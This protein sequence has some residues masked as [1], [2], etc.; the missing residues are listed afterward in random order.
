MDGR[1]PN[2]KLEYPCD[3]PTQARWFVMYVA[4]IGKSRG[5]VITHIDI[6]E[7]KRAE[8]EIQRLA[9]YDPLTNLANRRLLE[10]RLHHAVTSA[11]R[12]GAHGALFFID[13]DYFKALNDT[14]GHDVGDMLLVEVARRLCEVVREND[15]VAR[16]GGDE[17]VVLMEDLGMTADEAA[18][19]AAHLG[20]KLR[21]ALDVPFDLKGYE[22]YCKTSIGVG[23]F[24]GHNTVDELLKHADLAL[25]EA[26]NAGRGRLQFFDPAMQHALTRRSALESALRK[27]IALEQ[28]RLYYQPQIDEK[29]GVIGVEALLRWQH[30]QCGLVMPDHFISLAED[31]GL[32]LPVGH[33][34]LETACAQLKTW[35]SDRRN[36]QL[37]IAVNV[38]ARQFQQPDFVMQIQR[39]LVASGINPAR[40]K[41]ELT[42]SMLLED[43]NDAVAKMLEIKKLGVGLSM[44]DFGT[45]YSSLSHLAQLPLNQIKIDRSFVSNIQ[46]TRKDETIVQAIIRVGFELHMQVLAEGV[47]TERQRRFLEVNG[48]HEYQGFLFSKALPLPALEVFLKRA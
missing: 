40:L 30:P 3:A 20:D 28:L 46:R 8:A 6:T 32:I 11:A 23:L 15:T 7:R 37:Q 47:E 24:H 42:E 14:R 10:D 44:D 1:L 34:V 27:A 9:Y 4:P 13:L 21:A 31:T 26:K 18:S 22:Y 39:I 17:F 2:F 29:L 35:E 38:S 43:V 48:C 33:W 36:C 12:S 19:L 5:V 16:Q 25:Y 41:L 45:G